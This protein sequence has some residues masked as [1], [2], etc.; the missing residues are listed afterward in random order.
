MM[1]R[2]RATRRSASAVVESAFVLPVALAVIY[3]VVAGALAIMVYQQVAALSREA[4]R[5]ASVHGYYHCQDTAASPT[6]AADVYNNAILPRLVDM[7]PNSLGYAVTWSP[8]Q[9]QGSYVTVTVSYR[10][11]LPLYG[12]INFSSTSTTVMTW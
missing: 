6:T 3:A 8:D 11:S 10:M 2:S 7:D 1:M 9:K 5:Y 4:A 12:T